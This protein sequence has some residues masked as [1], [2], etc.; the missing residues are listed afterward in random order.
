MQVLLTLTPN[1]DSFPNSAIVVIYSLVGYCLANSSGI[2]GLK[3]G[4]FIVIEC[5]LRAI[6][7]GFLGTLVFYI[8]FGLYNW[9]KGKKYLLLHFVSL[10]SNS[11]EKIK[12]ES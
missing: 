6:S 3:G 7:I 5:E 11:V 1:A 9:S 12:I 8:Y 2:M 10:L 4:N